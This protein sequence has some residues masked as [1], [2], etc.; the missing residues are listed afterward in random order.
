MNNDISYSILNFVT[1]FGA[2]SQFVKCS[3]CG[4]AIKFTDGNRRGLGFKIL[5]NCDNCEQKQISSNLHIGLAYEIN[6]RFLLAVR[7]LGV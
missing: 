6:I 5:I 4:G 3:E 1:V 2:L 7:L